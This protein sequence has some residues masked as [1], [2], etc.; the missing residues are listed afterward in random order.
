MI[1]VGRAH[2]WM[3]SSQKEACGGPAQ[4]LTQ[5][6]S[7]SRPRSGS[8]TVSALLPAASHAIFAWSAPAARTGAAL[9]DQFST[10]CSCACLFCVRPYSTA[11]CGTGCERS[12]TFRSTKRHP[13]LL[14]GS[15][16]PL[17]GLTRRAFLLQKGGGAQKKA[18]FFRVFT[19]AAICGAHIGS[20]TGHRKCAKWSIRRT[21]RRT[22]VRRPTPS[23]PRARARRGRRRRTA[24]SMRRY[25]SNSRP[26][27]TVSHLGRRKKEI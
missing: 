18:G 16:F 12:A 24:A 7:S 15:F 25:G 13:R 4:Q 26:A 9:Y 10:L 17:R 21:S 1:P 19:A 6:L 22:P 14:N 3:S 11:V 8:S 2:L 20:M 23:R 27:R 5:Q